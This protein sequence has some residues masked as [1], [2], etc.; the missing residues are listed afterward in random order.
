MILALK[1]AQLL[2]RHPRGR[3]GDTL[4]ATHR[5]SFH[6]VDTADEGL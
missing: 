4:G 5:V 2:G 3:P 1:I 6:L